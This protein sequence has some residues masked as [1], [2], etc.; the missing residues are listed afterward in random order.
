MWQLSIRRI[1][2]RMRLLK[3]ENMYT[4]I[5]FTERPNVFEPELDL[6]DLKAKDF[7]P[8]NISK[9]VKLLYSLD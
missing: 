7:H 1:V 8:A 2:S 4:V 9:R 5:N 3:L 6:V